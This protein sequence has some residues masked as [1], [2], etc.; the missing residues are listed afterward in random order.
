MTAQHESRTPP[1]PDSGAAGIPNPNASPMGAGAV[2][3]PAIHLPAWYDPSRDLAFQMLPALRF[4]CC[5]ER[6]PHR[7]EHCPGIGAA[8]ERV[9][10]RNERPLESHT[11]IDYMLDF[12]A[13]GRGFTGGFEFSIGSIARACMPGHA[14]PQDWYDDATRRFLRILPDLDFSTEQARREQFCAWHGPALACAARCGASP[15]QVIEVLNVICFAPEV[16]NVDLDFGQLASDVVA[17]F[18]ALT[19]SKADGDWGP[20]E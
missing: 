15:S 14:D 4:L 2:S 18:E 17:R 7:G 6:E 1:T 3:A 9:R 8:W 5:V 19:K 13:P 11:N 10:T 20:W 16:A 12:L